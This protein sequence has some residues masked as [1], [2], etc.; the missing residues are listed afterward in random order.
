LAQKKAYDAVSKIEWEDAYYRK[1]IGY[2]AV[3]RE[4]NELS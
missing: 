1:D 3:K 2:K 4:L